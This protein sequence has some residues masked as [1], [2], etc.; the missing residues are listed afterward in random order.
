MLFFQQF[1]DAFH[2]IQ[3]IIYE[4][5]Q[6]RNDSQ[7]MTNTVSQFKTN[8]LGIVIDV[9]IKRADEPVK[10]KD[11]SEFVERVETRKAEKAAALEEAKRIVE[12]YESAKA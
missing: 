9:L 8:G 6:F 5:L 4:K 1:I 7:L 12:E 2:I 10:Y 3:R 11:I